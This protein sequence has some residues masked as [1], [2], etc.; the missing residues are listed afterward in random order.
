MAND[1]RT[2]AAEIPSS[3][4]D[5]AINWAVK[6]EFNQAEPATR[7]AFERWLQAQPVHATAWQRVLS[8]K[9]DFSAMPSALALNTLQAVETQRKVHGLNRRQALKLLMLA[10]VA[11]GSAWITHDHVPWQRVIADASTA[12]GEQRT[13][14][15]DDGTVLI[16]NTDTAV[17][18]AMSDARRMIVLRRGEISISTG[19]DQAF[20]NKR[21]FWVHT[22]FGTMQALGTR[23]VVRLDSARAR[24]SVREGAVQMHPSTGSSSAIANVGENWWL[25]DDSVT[26]AP[27]QGFK[28]DSWTDGVIAGE[29]MRLA[30]LLAELSRYRSG[31]IV[32]D[33]RV[34]DLR[35]SGIYHVRDTDQ[36]LKFLLQTQALTVTYYTRYWVAVGPDVQRQ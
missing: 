2:S 18:F 36:A 24:I 13:M 22:P 10:G 25:A 30:D 1:A 6:L 35:V 5:A 16:L 26:P 7:Q 23:F 8:L 11:V 28:A 20:I 17:S 21:P 31:R 27:D 33:E 15:L 14:Q 34:A 4:I 19:P 29:N 12:T 32:C 9:K 3:V